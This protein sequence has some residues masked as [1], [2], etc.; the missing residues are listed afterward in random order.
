MI[1]FD[2]VFAVI[3]VLSI[4][5]ALNVVIS[6]NPLHSILFLILVFFNLALLLL[7]QQIE[8]LALVVLIIYVGAIAVLFLFVIY[9]LNIKLIQVNEQN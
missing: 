1:K 5:S 8:F 3:A 2:F 4:F 7:L 6:K 9:M